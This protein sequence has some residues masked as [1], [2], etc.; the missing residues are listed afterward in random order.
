MATVHFGRLLGPV[1][2]SRTV[3]IKRLHAH[4]ASDPE[5]VS[6]FLDEA[7]LA[8]RIR[9][10]NVITTLDVVA[11]SG[12]LFLVMEYVPGETLARL[13]KNVRDAGR[14]MPHR[15]VSSVISGVLHGLHAAHE[16]KD[17]RGMPLGIVHRDVSPQ[18]TH[19]GTDGVAR[20][21]D[22]GVA[23]AA[24]RIQTTREGQIKGKLAYMAPEQLRG[25]TIDRSSD[26]YAAGVMLWELITGT[27]L[28]QG[29]NEGVVVARV[30][31]GKI[32]A[33]SQVLMRAARST[34]SERTYT[35]LQRLDA[36]VL[37]AVNPDPKQRFATARDMALELE[38][39]V[40]PA[41]LSQVGEWV[42]NNAAEVLAQRAEKVSEIEVQS[43]T[44]A[45]FD[46]PSDVQNFMR[47][48]TS[49]TMALGQHPSQPQMFPTEAART[50]AFQLSAPSNP[51]TQPSTIS[52][53]ASHSTF[54]APPTNGNRGWFLGAAGVGALVLLGLVG[55]ALAFSRRP[56]APVVGAGEATAVPGPSIDTPRVPTAFEPPSA[57]VISDDSPPAPSVTA[58]GKGTGPSASATHRNA[59]PPHTQG[60]GTVRPPAT[61]APTAAPANDP[62]DPPTYIEDGIVKYKKGCLGK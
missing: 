21:L 12:E 5:F 57:I 42:E 30:L 20:L 37:R 16:A 43:T 49:E 10:P 13:A 33:P 24:G 23:K 29:E 41:T 36:C 32:P 44:P 54:Q 38:A 62:C 4:F 6:M 55:G 27:R 56:K 3:A 59:W 22:F 40:Q 34:F 45:P 7:R 11:T 58:P 47:T 18:N 48:N 53:S 15:I 19:V 39:C 28:F 31:E 25:A 61:A 51:V 46:R 1:G 9:H 26:I 35:Q 50:T 8:A 52:V 17:E 2:F 60:Q 14:P